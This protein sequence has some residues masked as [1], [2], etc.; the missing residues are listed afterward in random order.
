MGYQKIYVDVKCPHCNK[1]SNYKIYVDE[2]TIFCNTC[3]KKM[4]IEV[5]VQTVD[6]TVT[7]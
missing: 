3:N 7:K 2:D 6:I 1:V 5:V 4:N